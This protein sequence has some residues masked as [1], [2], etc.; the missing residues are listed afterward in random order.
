MLDGDGLFA[1]AWAAEGAVLVLPAYNCGIPI[2][3]CVRTYRIC[4]ESSMGVFASGPEC[5]GQ[6]C[7]G[8][9]SNV[10][11]QDIWRAKG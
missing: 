4:Q 1:G 3:L 7:Q 6:L 8:R 9:G 5:C 11:R 2:Q 10:P